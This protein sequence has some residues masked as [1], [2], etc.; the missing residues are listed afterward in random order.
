LVDRLAG[1]L[2]RGDGRLRAVLTV[3]A[4]YYGHFARHPALARL[5]GDNTLLVGPMTMSE[6]RRAIEEPARVAGLE[7]EEGFADAVLAD[8]RH[9]PGALPLL[10]TALLATWERRDGRVLRV[11]AYREAGG[12]AGALTRLADGV[13]GGLDAAGQAATRRVFLRLT[14]PGEDGGE[15]RRR[16]PRP[17]LAGSEQEEAVL[18]ALVERRLVTAD[19]D[20][21]EVAHE[22]LLREWPRL[23]AWLDEDRDGRRVHRH[24]TEAAG[25]WD[26]AGRDP[27]DLYRGARLDAA[28]EWA[29]AHPGDANPLEQAFLAASAAAQERTLHGARRTARRLRTLASVLAGLLVVA[30]ASAVVAVT[31]TRTANHQAQVA[32]DA[33]RSA[34][35]SRLATLAAS[36]GADRVDLALLLGVG[37]YQLAP[38]RDAEG[39]LVTALA[40]TPANLDQIIRFDTPGLLPV[41]NPSVSRDGRLLAVPGQDGTVTVRDLR[42]GRVQRT[43]HWPTGRQLAIFSADAT[44][45][46]VG[47]NDGTIVVWDVTSGEQV[48]APIRAGDGLAYGQFDPDDPSRLFAVDNSGQVV[49]WDRSVPDAPRQVGPPLHFPLNPGDIPLVVVNGDGTRLA[50]VAFGGTSTRVWDARSGAF[51]RD[52]PGRLGFF[53]PDGVTLPTALGDRV[54]LWNVDTGQM[55][56][57]LTGFTKAAPGMVISNDGRRMVADDDETDLTRIFDLPSGQLVA[58]LSLTERATNPVAFMPDGRLLTS[59]VAEADIWRIDAGMSSP[60]GQTLNG[61]HGRVV[62]TFVPGGTEIATQGVDDRQILLWDTATGRIEGPLLGG[63]V[64][65]PAAFSPDGTMLAA[66]GR[67]GTVRLWGRRWRDHGVAAP[68]EAQVPGALWER[69]DGAELAVLTAIQPTG[70]THAV[71]WSPVGQDVAVVSDGSVLL[72]DVRDPRQPRLVGQLATADMLQPGVPD[73]L[74]LAFSH[75]GRRLAVEDVPGRTVTLFD[76]A[77]GQTVWSQR[78]DTTG[79]HPALVFSPDDATLAVGYGTVAAG[80]VEFRDAGTGAVQR[81]LPTPSSGGVEFLRGGSVM[82]TTSTVSGRDITQLWDTATLAP[83]G[84]SLPPIGGP[85]TPSRYEYSLARDPEGTMA[86]AGTSEGVITIWHVGVELWRAVA[87]HIAGRN[88]TQQE[89][90]RYFPGEPYRR[91]CP[92]WPEGL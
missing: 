4:D 77:T 55:R 76:A 12:V 14:T 82:M 15:L 39:G 2:E 73:A 50:A 19:G 52:L 54:V 5:I 34:Q 90:L 62:G 78:L 87:C 26:A 10:S 13:Y 64:E 61:H 80:V 30:L 57:V 72:W 27:A 24:L 67:D 22:A 17:E 32:H 37:S 49:L 66:P 29:T 9:E 48:G 25:A 71:A 53:A 41:V 47:G 91:T 56:Q 84:E 63:A 85:L 46:A 28:Q 83:I 44:M 59:D 69:A 20:T 74:R 65:A 58:A 68:P 35:A 21:V 16:A 89:W 51:L 31:Q 43:F 45:L 81:R 70:R 6:L 8:I 92:Q 40:H 38:S 86:A 42:T 88:L 79:G 7:L 60:L 75:D 23:R 18:A 33:T 3:R 1:A 11:A 36:L